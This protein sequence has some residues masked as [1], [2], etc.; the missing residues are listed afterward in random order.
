MCDEPYVKKDDDGYIVEVGIR[1]DDRIVSINVDELEIKDSMK[2]KVRLAEKS[3]ISDKQKREKFTDEKYN[4]FNLK[5]W[6]RM[7]LM[8]DKD[9]L[10]NNGFDEDVELTQ[11]RLSR[12][13]EF[14]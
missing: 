5:P 1:V 11:K 10:S 13:M 3:H 6:Q 9:V 7:V 8:D 4:Y 14:R 2:H 12:F